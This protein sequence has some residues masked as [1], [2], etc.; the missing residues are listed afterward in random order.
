MHKSGI[1]GSARGSVSVFVGPSLYPFGRMIMCH[2]VADTVEELH[3]MADWIGV[4]RKHFQTKTK[5][6]YD[7]S[8]TKRALA[9]E[10]GAIETT[11]RVLLLVLKQAER[12]EA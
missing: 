6:H 5:P 1:R 12:A 8:K 9:V 10:F 11:E 7:I 4:D 2:M 3:E